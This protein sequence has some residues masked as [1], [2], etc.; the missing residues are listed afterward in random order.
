MKQFKDNEGRTWDVVM[1]TT[2][3]KRVRSLLGVDLMQ[4]ING[5]LVAKMQADPALV[6]DVAYVMC[7]DQADE[8]G[9][10]DEDFGR[11][12][13]GDPIAYATQAV[14]DEF[15]E[16]CPDPRDR[17]ALGRVLAAMRAVIDRKMTEREETMTQ[18][19]IEREIEKAV[20]ASLPTR[21]GSSTSAPASP[22]ST[23]GR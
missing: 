10:S 11:A 21:G 14:L 12:M 23:P 16:Y 18:E 15:C 20:D 3:L 9:V 22:A 17:A 2:A 19:A 4:L 13:R 6:V 7:K 5:D 8:R 1:D